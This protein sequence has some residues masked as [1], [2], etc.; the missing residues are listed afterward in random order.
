MMKLDAFLRP[1]KSKLKNK[2]VSD[3]IDH[4]ETGQHYTVLFLL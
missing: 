2:I 4:K 1:E 3:Y